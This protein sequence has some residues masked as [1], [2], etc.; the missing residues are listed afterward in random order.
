M[1]LEAKFIGREYG[2][3][4]YEIGK[5]KIKEYEELFSNPYCAAN[6]GFVDAVIVP[7]ETRL[8]LIEALEIMCSKREIRPTKKHGNIPM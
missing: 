4:T 3:L 7:S 6:R 2:P 8:R 5:E 1:A